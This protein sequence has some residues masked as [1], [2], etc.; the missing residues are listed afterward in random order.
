MS[1][2]RRTPPT[3]DAQR[4]TDLETALGKLQLDYDM[5][6]VLHGALERDGDHGQCVERIDTMRHD[7]DSAREQSTYLNQLVAELQD[8]NN[9]RGCTHLSARAWA[10]DAGQ[11]VVRLR[12]AIAT[13]KDE[14]RRL[15]NDA[16]VDALDGAL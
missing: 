4:I 8:E 12:R 16:P 9:D 2:F 3:P 10:T 6:R 5:L 11:E 1:L 14:N 15:R 7:L 13:L